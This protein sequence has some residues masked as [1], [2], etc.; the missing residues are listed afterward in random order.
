MAFENG[1]PVILLDF[2][3]GAVLIGVSRDLIPID[4]ERS[5]LRVD[6]L[7]LSCSGAVAPIPLDLSAFAKS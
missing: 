5:F 1:L 2:V 4:F 7:N 3:G 6:R